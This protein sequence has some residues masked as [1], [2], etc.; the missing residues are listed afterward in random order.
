MDNQKILTSL[1]TELV[2]Y[3]KKLYEKGMVNLFEGNL[4]IKEGDLVLMTPSSQNK[5][6]MTIDMI[7][8]MDL[9][10]NLLSENGYQPSSEYQMH[11][12]IYR[13]RPDI[14]AVVHD[15]STFA[16][17]YALTG[18]PIQGQLAELFLFFGGEIPCCAYG[19]PGTNA[20]FTEFERRFVHEKKDVVLLANHGI[21]AAGKTLEE[22]FAKAEAAEKIAKITL[23]AKLLGSENPLPTGAIDELMNK[24]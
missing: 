13:L 20:V 3:F 17:A 21:T 15:H 22:A 1:K 8:E 5:E 19:T 24:K 7:V 18:Q 16:C 6:T 9:D 2:S 14:S 4:S 11:L 10:G 23:L 12:E